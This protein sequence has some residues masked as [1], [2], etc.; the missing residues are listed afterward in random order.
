[1]GGWDLTTTLSSGNPD[2]YYECF[3]EL[4]QRHRLPQR[5]CMLN[6]VTTFFGYFL[7]GT[8][9]ISQI[10][11]I[12]KI[13]RRR[14]ASGVSFVS[15]ILMLQASS[16]KVA[17]CV[18][19]N[20]PF[21]AWGENLV[22]MVEMV[23]LVLL[24]LSYNKRPISA[25]IQIYTNHKNHDTGQLSGTSSFLCVFQSFGRISTSILLTRDWILILTFV[26]LLIS[27]LILTLQ[28]IYYRRKNRKLK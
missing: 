27:N 26:Q 9:T 12:L 10:P 2:H 23:V 24:L 13:L 16:S 8:V 11:Q 6:L 28:V 15:I 20:F 19:Q 1:M 4:V 25:I 3:Q 18:Q 14:N 17:Y 7:I 22:L 5:Q 21:S